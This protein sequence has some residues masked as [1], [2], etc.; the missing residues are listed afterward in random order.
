[1]IIFYSLPLPSH[2]L[3]AIKNSFAKGRRVERD[4]GY[5]LETTF[6]SGK[7]KPILLAKGLQMWKSFITPMEDL[8]SVPSD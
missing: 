2:C 4:Q 3:C 7:S 8:F 6:I 5:A 1:M